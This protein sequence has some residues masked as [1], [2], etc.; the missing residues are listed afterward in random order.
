[1]HSG[2][3]VEVTNKVNVSRKGRS[4]MPITLGSFP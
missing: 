4:A 3:A 1:V 2:D